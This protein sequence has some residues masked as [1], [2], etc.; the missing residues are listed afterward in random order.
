M[1]AIGIKAAAELVE[2][3]LDWIV[4]QDG[5]GMNGSGMFYAAA[6][7]GTHL[8]TAT[9]NLGEV[10]GC[11]IAEAFCNSGSLQEGDQRSFAVQVTLNT[12]AVDAWRALLEACS[13][14]AS[15]QEGIDVMRAAYGAN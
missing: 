11:W 8:G 5:D 10:G 4:T 7:V 6:T 15:L 13:H 12:N 14:T 1:D 3:A 2:P 9:V